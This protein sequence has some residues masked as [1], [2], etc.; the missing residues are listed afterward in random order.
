MQKSLLGLVGLVAL[1]C[2]CAYRADPRY[3]SG[4]TLWGGAKVDTLQEKPLSEELLNRFKLEVR[5]FWQAPYVWG[6]AS[7]QGTDC[8]G[9]IYVIYQRAAGVRL[10][11][12]T[13][14]LY[15]QG[16]PIPSRY[17]RFSDL[18]FFSDNGNRK[19]SHVGL[20][21]DR[22]FFIHASVSQGVRLSRLSEQPYKD[23][24]IGARRFLN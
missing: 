18:V 15:E 7:P 21:I 16:A 3:G 13:I 5:R 1:L 4:P 24:Y 23:H 12:Q 8:S 11:R 20:Y 22:G 2:A 14:E 17:L 10:P 6:G 9:L 19:V